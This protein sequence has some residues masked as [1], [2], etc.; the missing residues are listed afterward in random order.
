VIGSKA[1]TPR[2]AVLCGVC[3]GVAGTGAMTLWQTISAKLQETEESESE[4][5]PAD[6]WE[7]APAPAK[8]AKRVSEGVFDKDVSAELIPTLSNVMH[9]AY[10]T[11][12]GAI[13]SIAVAGRPGATVRRGAIFGAAVW[14]SSYLQ[15][16]PMGIYQP[17]WKYQPQELA[18][19]LSYHFVYGL[20]VALA[21]ELLERR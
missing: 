20:G 9:W 17:P 13:Y 3:A 19:D 5:P 8:V 7:Q 1:L 11:S 18:L 21:F 4:T 12:W 6:P 16:V 2:A 15:L 10:G 14:G